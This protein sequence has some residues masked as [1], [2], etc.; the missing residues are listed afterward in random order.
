MVATGGGMSLALAGVG[1]AGGEVVDA[2]TGA[3]GG[4]VEHRRRVHVQDMRD[5]AYHVAAV[6]LLFTP[7]EPPLW[8]LLVTTPPD[9][10][11]RQEHLFVDGVFTVPEP[12]TK[13]WSMFRDWIE[14]DNPKLSSA[15]DTMLLHARFGE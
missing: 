4:A 3:A 1:A 5:S 9:P 12:G 11:G 14:R 6:S 2:A 8:D 15:V 10:K 7:S 13:T